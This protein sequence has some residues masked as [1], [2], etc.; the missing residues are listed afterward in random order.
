MVGCIDLWIRWIGKLSCWKHDCHIISLWTVYS[1]SAP[2]A[3]SCE[4]CGIYKI[5]YPLSTGPNCGDPMYNKLNCDYSIGRVRFMMPRGQSY[6]V[7]WI[8]ENARKFYIRT[9][10]PYHCD[11]N[12]QI[13]KPDSPFNVTNWC[14]KE[15]EIEVSWLP[16]PEPPCNELVDCNDWPHSTCRA[17]NEGNNRCL[18]DSKDQWNASN[19][20]CTQG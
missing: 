7:T 5:P 6:R 1:C 2:T 19:L 14:F 8:D 10:D 4:P 13:N 9:S 15:D 3:K 18:C 11:I 12:Y 20:T 16:A 17:T